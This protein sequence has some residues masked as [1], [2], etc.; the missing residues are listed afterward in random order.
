MSEPDDLD[1]DDEDSV[2][3]DEPQRVMVSRLRLRLRQRRTKMIMTTNRFSILNQRTR[4]AKEGEVEEE[5]VGKVRMWVRR[6]IPLDRSRL[7]LGQSLSLWIGLGL[8]L[9]NRGA[10]DK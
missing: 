6:M 9:P 5:E 2:R 4:P 3:E 1:L 7:D 8:E 10:Q